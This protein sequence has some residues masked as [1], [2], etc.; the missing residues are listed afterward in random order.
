[1]TNNND[2]NGD[3]ISLSNKNND[4]NDIWNNKNNTMTIVI[5][6]WRMLRI[7]KIV[8]SV[9]FQVIP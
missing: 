9:Y 8:E 3:N 6:N 4:D 1:M 7:N 5:K 2:K